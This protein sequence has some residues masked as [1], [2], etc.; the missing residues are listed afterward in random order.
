M[1]HAL[2]RLP[3]LRMLQGLDVSSYMNLLAQ[4]QAHARSPV[5][6]SFPSDFQVWMHG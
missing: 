4:S 6:V 1:E 3:Y 5:N 2:G